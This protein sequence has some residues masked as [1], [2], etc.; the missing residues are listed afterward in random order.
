LY[1]QTLGED[2]LSGEVPLVGGAIPFLAVSY[3]GGYYL[4][5]LTSDGRTDFRFEW[6]INE[7][8]YQTHSDSLY[9]VYSDRLMD[10]PLGPNASQIDFQLGRWFLN[11]TKGSADLFFT[12]RA[13]KEAENHLVPPQFYGP[14]NMLHHERSAGIAFDLLTIP[15]TS[16]LRDDVFAFGRTHLSMEYSNHMN[17]GPP[18]AF[19]AVASISIG[20]KPNWD[21]WSWTK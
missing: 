12:D 21:G 10:D 9:W 16:R 4:P 2:N 14:Q 5:R 19:R 3:Q 13:P 11:L 20:L 7:P 15:Q 8:N 1:V 6:K 17:F 18:G